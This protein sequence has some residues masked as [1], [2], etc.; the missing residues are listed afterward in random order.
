MV[1]KSLKMRTKHL[2]Q[3]KSSL[4]LLLSFW[5]LP[6]IRSYWGLCSMDQCINLQIEASFVMSIDK[7]FRPN[8]QCHPAPPHSQCDF[9]VCVWYHLSPPWENRLVSHW[10]YQRQG[11]NGNTGH[12]ALTRRDVGR[13]RSVDLLLLAGMY[14]VQVYSHH[15]VHSPHWW[16]HANPV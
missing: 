10:H 13:G 15:T 14:S 4:A 1:R 9:R 8:F 6:T 2:S 5:T 11:G 3:L 7:M 12:T 16:S